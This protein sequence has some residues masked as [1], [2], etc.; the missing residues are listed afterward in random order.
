MHTGL[1]GQI[2]LID[3]DQNRVKGEVMDLAHGLPFVSP[4]EIRA[5]D[6]SDCVDAD[7]IAVTAGAKQTPGQ[8]RPDLVRR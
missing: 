3:I 4:V 5:G 8:S 6:Y 1:A 7:L 2:V